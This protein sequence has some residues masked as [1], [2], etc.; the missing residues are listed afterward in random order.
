MITERK[1]QEVLKEHLGTMHKLNFESLFRNKEIPFIIAEVGSNWYTLDDCRK[2]I[3]LAKACKADAVKFQLF[4]HEELYGFPGETM[5]GTL[6]REWVPIL[7]EKARAS[8][9]EF[10]CSAFS[11]EGYEYINEYVNIHKIASSELSNWPILQYLATTGKPILLS[12]GGGWGAIDLERALLH[13]S[14]SDNLDF[15]SLSSKV[16]L[17]HCVSSYP[18]SGAALFRINALGEQ[19]PSLLVGYSDHTLD[20]F[21]IPKIAMQLG[22]RVIEKH[23]NFVDAEN[24]SDA[25]HS[26]S[27]QSFKDMVEY[28]GADFIPSSYWCRREQMPMMLQHN[29]RLIAVRPIKTGEGMQLGVNVGFFRSKVRDTS[30]AS[31]FRVG[32]DDISYATKSYNIGDG[33][34]WCT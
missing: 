25:L 10:M 16:I 17:M 1:P 33:V 22:A 8:G 20:C 7:A 30:G 12:T 31:C 34:D 32:A 26:I 11:V 28:L 9:I 27:L 13:L 5:Q 14:N 18:A 24:T 6:T 15:P 29:R 23:V 19:F 21:D 3:Q 2:S 4:S